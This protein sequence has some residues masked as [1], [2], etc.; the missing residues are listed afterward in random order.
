MATAFRRS[1][2]PAPDATLWDLMLDTLGEV[3][4]LQREMNRLEE[5]MSAPG[6]P[7]TGPA[8]DRL[9]AEYEAVTERFEQAGGYDLEHR[10]EQML[11]GLGFKPRQFDTPLAQLSGGQKTRAALARALLSDPDVLLLDEPTNHL[12]QIGRAHV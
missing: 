9:I 1:P 4:D 3:R 12:D 5:A 2:A 11:E 7:Q 10:I 8:W 6:A